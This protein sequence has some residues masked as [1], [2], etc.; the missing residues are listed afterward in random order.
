MID[1]KLLR[2]RKTR[3]LVVCG[4]P[5][6][7]V[8]SALPAAVSVEGS[9]GGV[10]LGGGYVPHGDSAAPNEKKGDVS[11]VKECSKLQCSDLLLSV[12][13]N[14]NQVVSFL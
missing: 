3:L 12:A 5:Q 14:K 6:T 13:A 7:E 4:A 9:E 10:G 8:P 2:G 1:D 11:P